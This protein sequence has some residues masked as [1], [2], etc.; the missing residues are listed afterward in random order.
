VSISKRHHFIPKYYLNNFTNENNTFFVF[1]KKHPK[2]ILSRSPK[3]VCYENHR[4]SIFGKSN[5]PHPYLEEEVYSF[6]DNNHAQIF[7]EFCNEVVDLKYWSKE[8]VQILEFF[9]PFLYWR[10]PKN[11]QDFDTILDSMNSLHDLDLTISNGVSGDEIVDLEIHKEILNTPDFRKV[12]RLNY[13]FKTFQHNI[14]KYKEL[15]WRVYDCQGFGGFV[16]SD[17]PLL[18]RF[19]RTEIAD[20][21]GD[22]IFPISPSRSFMRI[23]ENREN[24]FPIPVIQ[25]FSQIQN[26]D[27][28]VIC[29]NKEYLELLVSEYNRLSNGGDINDLLKNLWVF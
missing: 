24:N 4:N 1:D 14:Q 17:N 3:Q 8:R 6:F 10:N 28:F 18:F 21:R 11:D 20:L 23:D 5:I 15:E 27:R 29:H 13:G 9:V 26:A 16:T 25:N 2:K 7:Y 22:V 12:A 19:K